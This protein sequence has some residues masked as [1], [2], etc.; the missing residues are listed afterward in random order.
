[1]WPLPELLI[2]W[3]WKSCVSVQR[4][5]M[6]PS[7]TR[8]RCNFSPIIAPRSDRPNYCAHGLTSETSTSTSIVK[9]DATTV[10][11]EVLM[12]RRQEFPCL[13]SLL[14][15]YKSLHGCISALAFVRLQGA[16]FLK[17][18]DRRKRRRRTSS[19]VHQSS[20]SAQSAQYLCTLLRAAANREGLNARAV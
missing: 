15:P 13:N 8:R 9:L 14:V 16:R 20:F 6:F 10:K 7:S 19:G 11:F 12:H 17:Q 4:P 3:P 2:R 1:M 5:R 18:C